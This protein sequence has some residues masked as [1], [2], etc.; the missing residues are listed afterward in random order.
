MLLALAMKGGCR[1]VSRPNGWLT[2]DLSW[3]GNYFR[4]EIACQLALLGWLCARS[5]LR[6]GQSVELAR[7]ACSGPSV[8]VPL[9]ASFAIDRRRKAAIRQRSVL[10]Q[11]FFDGYTTHTHTHTHRE[12]ERE[13]ERER[14]SETD[15]LTSM[16]GAEVQWQRK[17]VKTMQ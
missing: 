4:G 7:C 8:S 13:R 14:Q 6:R 16:Y 2:G 5:L 3:R 15:N 10:H 1:T 17:V 9:S 12:R 11:R